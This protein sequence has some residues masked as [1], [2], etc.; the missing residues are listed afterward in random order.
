MCND[1]VYKP[2]STNRVIVW[3][4]VHDTKTTDKLL[5]QDLIRD[6][7]IILVPRI[8]VIKSEHC[9]AAF[10]CIKQI[11]WFYFALCEIEICIT[12]VRG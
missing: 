3:I 4:F 5:V 2:R 12:P 7:Q 6:E 8:L 1:N 9:R 10:Y 11:S